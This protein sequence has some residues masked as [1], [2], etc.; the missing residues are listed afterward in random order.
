MVE[1]AMD[2]AAT[3]PKRGSQTRVV[4]KR[5][6]AIIKVVLTSCH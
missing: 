3:L 6:S 2:A 4:S 5:R 1:V